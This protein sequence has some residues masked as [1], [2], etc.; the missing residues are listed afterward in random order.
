MIQG[1]HELM[2]FS[3]RVTKVRIAIGSMVSS[4]K[5]A[6][7]SVSIKT[8]SNRT[9]AL[10]LKSFIDYLPVLCADQP[11]HEH[12]INAVSQKVN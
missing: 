12:A 7:P 6:L 1:L 5:R 11:L 2:S 10:R 3:P 9:S 8:M 4:M